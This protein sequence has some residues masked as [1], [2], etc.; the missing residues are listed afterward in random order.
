MTDEVFGEGRRAPQTRKDNQPT[1]QVE[2]LRV[3]VLHGSHERGKKNEK[4]K[5][6]ENEIFLREEDKTK[7]WRK[8]G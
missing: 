3:W 7:K 4:K 6:K 2:R 8:R 5:V 1:A